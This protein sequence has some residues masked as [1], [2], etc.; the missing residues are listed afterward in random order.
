MDM[1]ENEDFQR[2]KFFIQLV[3][4]TLS[5][6]D[7]LQKA[8]KLEIELSAQSYNIILFKCHQNEEEIREQYSEI[9]VQMENQI[10]KSFFVRNHMILFRRPLEGWAILIKGSDHEPASA[11]TR[12]CI[13]ELET[14]FNSNQNLDYFIGVGMPVQRLQQINKTFDEHPRLCL[15][16]IS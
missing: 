11:V 14:M 8:K 4:N 7:L 5:V 15:R 2:K 12:R 10:Q 1:Q 16:Y 13:K 9:V 6:P 3:E